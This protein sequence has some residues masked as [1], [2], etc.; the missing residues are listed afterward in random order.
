MAGIKIKVMAQHLIAGLLTN[1]AYAIIIEKVLIYNL[2]LRCSLD[3][4]TADQLNLDHKHLSMYSCINENKLF[5]Y[6]KQ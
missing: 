3:F 1:M 4:F 6:L 5:Q 2:L